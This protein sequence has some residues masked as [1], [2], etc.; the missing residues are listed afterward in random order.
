MLAVYGSPVL[1]VK[2]LQPR[3]PKGH[4]QHV[5][6]RPNQSSAV[7]KAGFHAAQR[8]EITKVPPSSGPLTFCLVTS[9]EVHSFSFT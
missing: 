4:F 1:K 9:G 5:C 8:R 6:V 3:E 7:R 2:V